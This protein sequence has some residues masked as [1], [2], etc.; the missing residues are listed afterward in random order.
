[1]E[2]DEFYRICQHALTFDK[3]GLAFLTFEDLQD[4][5]VIQDSPEGVLLKGFNHFQKR[6]ELVFACNEEKDFLKMTSLY[7]GFMV[8]FVCPEWKEDLLKRGFKVLGEMRDYWIQDISSYKADRKL[9]FGA[10]EEAGEISSVTLDCAEES[11]EFAG[12]TPEFILSWLKGTEP[13]LLA[14]KAS[15]SKIIV[16]RLNG[17]IIGVAVV[18]VYGS[19]ASRGS[20]CWLRELAVSRAYQHQGWGRNLILD[21]LAYG[22]SNKAKRAFLSADEENDSARHLYL[23]C[24]FVPEANEEQLDLITPAVSV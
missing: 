18:A 12:E 20:I 21:A 6:N 1:M 23:S 16:K 14:A 8:Q 9:D 4:Y 3:S 22:N 24:G 5:E 11:R 17:R 15:S 7:S 19:D 10:E 13:N 2:K